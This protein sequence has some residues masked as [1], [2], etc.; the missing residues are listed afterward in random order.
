MP[1]WVAS[2]RKGGRQ[3]FKSTPPQSNYRPG[4][5]DA[6]ALFM[7]DAA[8]LVHAHTRPS[9]QRGNGL[10]GPLGVT[11]GVDNFVDAKGA[12]FLRDS[13]PRCERMKDWDIFIIVDQ[14]NRLYFIRLNLNRDLVKFV[15]FLLF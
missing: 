15:L 10:D 5:D 8:C 3:T 13:F 12:R 14:Y 7:A 4:H 9:T 6:H 1:L 11:G 2:V